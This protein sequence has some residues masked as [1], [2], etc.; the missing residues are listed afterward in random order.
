[1]LAVGNVGPTIALVQF[2]FGCN[3]ELARIPFQAEIS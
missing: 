2:V 3:I 1:V